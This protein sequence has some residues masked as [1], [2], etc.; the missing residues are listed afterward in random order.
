ML[1]GASVVVAP[2]PVPGAPLRCVV[3]V[4]VVESTVWSRP[5][6]TSF[7]LLEMLLMVVMMVET[8]FCWKSF[9]VVRFV[10]WIFVVV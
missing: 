10:V 9:D 2:Q 4:V 8:L 7:T 1:G 5:V 6:S 3:V